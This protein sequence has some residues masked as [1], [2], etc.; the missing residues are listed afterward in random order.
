MSV[1]YTQTRVTNHPMF[2][3]IG[4]TTADWQPIAPL[5]GTTPDGVAYNIPLFLPDADKVAAIGGGRLLT[6]FDD[7]AT[8]F[9]G[10]EVSL[11]KRMSNRWMVRLA[12][13]YNNPQEHYDMAVPVNENGNPTRTDTFPLIRRRT[14]GA[15]QRRQR[16]GRR[17]RQPALELQRQRRLSAAVGHGSGRQPVRQAG[18]A[19]SVLPQRG[20]RSRRH[21]SA[22]C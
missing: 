21:A 16:I 7:Y 12:G 11:N 1:N 8:T 5:T 4:L 14:V 10:L 9:N 22:S 3:F 15:A 19:V 6:N 13:A 17:V 2:P 18:H 20:A